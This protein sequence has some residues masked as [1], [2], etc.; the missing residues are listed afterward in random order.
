[1]RYFIRIP[2]RLNGPELLNKSRMQ[3]WLTIIQ[4]NEKNITLQVNILNVKTIVDRLSYN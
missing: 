2:A 4:W 3:K 1:M